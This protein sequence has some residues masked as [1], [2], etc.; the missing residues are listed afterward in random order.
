MI[1]EGNCFQVFLTSVRVMQRKLRKISSMYRAYEIDGLMRDQTQMLAGVLSS[2]TD[3]ALASRLARTCMA[4]INA[5]TWFVGFRDGLAKMNLADQLAVADKIIS[6]CGEVQS[7]LHDFYA[8]LGA[9]DGLT[10]DVAQCFDRTKES[11]MEL[12]EELELL[13]WDAMELQ[14]DADVSA[15][16]VS[17]P[18]TTIESLVTSLTH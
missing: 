5:Y 12:F 3:G 17:G 18:F 6:A 9:S 2:A 8:G 16:R 15:G 14:A 4:F 1:R 7:Q 10:P 13:R 11:A